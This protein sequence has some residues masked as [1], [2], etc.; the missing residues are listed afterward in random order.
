MGESPLWDPDTGLWWL[1]ITGQRLLHRTATGHFSGVELSAQVSAVELGPAPGSDL[2]AVL[3][4]SGFGWLGPST[5]TIHPFAT[6]PLVGDER[7]NDAGID[8][9]GRCWAGSH[10]ATQAAGG[11]LFR[12]AEDGARSYLNELG[13]SNGLDWAPDGG[14]LYHADST[15]GTVTAYPYRP[16]TGELERGTVLCRI[17]P[18][19]GLPDGLTVDATGAVWLALW[20]GSQ[21][22]CLHPVSGSLLATVSVPTRNVT[23]CTFG[24]PVL[25][26]LFIT[27]AADE[28]DPNGGLLYACETAVR[29]L[30]PRRYRGE[31]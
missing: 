13:M 15:A 2:L 12:C 24:G 26:T 28:A 31:R 17:P 9:V 20:G 27:T 11:R 18:A 3:P 19:V 16:D 4:D 25:D 10:S 14:T 30:P 23:S 8:P 7:V 22:W 5:G 6:V 29:G 21:L 1:D